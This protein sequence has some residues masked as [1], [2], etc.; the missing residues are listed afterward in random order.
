M[1]DPKKL[2]AFAQQKKGGAAPGKKKGNPFPPKKIEPKNGN[3]DDEHED[4][5]DDE[6]DDHEHDARGED[7]DG[8]PGDD[9]DADEEKDKSGGALDEQISAALEDSVDDLNGILDELEWQPGSGPDGHEE[10]LQPG[11]CFAKLRDATSPETAKG[12]Q[13]WAKGGEWED[14]TDLGE[15][16][17]VDDP[18]RFAGFLSALKKGGGKQPPQ[19]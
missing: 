8:N 13:K 14:F 3:A 19:K 10:P 2:Q 16:I 17:G 9:H 7:T 5:E 11:Q 18:E 4:D 15:D 6:D 1:V 12:V